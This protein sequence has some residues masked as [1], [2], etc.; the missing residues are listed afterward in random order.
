MRQPK[1]PSSWVTAF[2]AS[3]EYETLSDVPETPALTEMPPSS[4]TLT[5]TYSP[6]LWVFLRSM[7]PVAYMLAFEIKG[8]E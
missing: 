8:L 3:A 1:L 2:E 6:E 7:N 5:P 4:G